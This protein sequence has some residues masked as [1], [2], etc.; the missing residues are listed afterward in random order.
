MEICNVSDSNL[1]IQEKEEELQRLQQ[2][3]A[4]S[5]AEMDTAMEDSRRRLETLLQPSLSRPFNAPLASSSNNN[6]ASSHQHHL[7]L[8]N[9]AYYYAV[10]EPNNSNNNAPQSHDVALSSSSMP[11]TEY[12][13]HPNAFG[14]YNTL[15]QHHQ[16]R[17]KDALMRRDAQSALYWKWRQDRVQHLSRVAAARDPH[18]LKQAQQSMQRF[19]LTL[20]SFHQS[21]R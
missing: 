12:I 4:A 3:L 6:A 15:D 17:E 14:S 16:A 20:A 8:L 9:S 5:S 2:R 1:C 18:T 21:Q 19:Q 11:S 7:H 13:D 10:A